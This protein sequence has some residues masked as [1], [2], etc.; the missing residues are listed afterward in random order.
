MEKKIN[1]WK[2]TVIFLVLLA[3]ATGGFF[4]GRSFS[5]IEYIPG[6][7]KYLPG[8]P[9]HDTIKIDKPVKIKEPVDTANIIAQCVCDGIYYEL[10][11]EK[12][13]DSIV[14]VSKED[15]TAILKDYATEKY[16]SEIL[17]DTDTLGKCT[18]DTK[19]QYNKLMAMSYDFVPVTR[20]Q[21]NTIVK[22]KRFSPFMG[23]GV[24]TLPAAGVCVGGYINEK[25]GLQVEGQYNINPKGIENFPKYDF[26]MKIL[27]KF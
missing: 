6:P 17:F 14:Y 4:L 1:W 22:T 2:I 19:I 24:S 15:T 3:F 27:R 21:T 7:I 20:S 11:P 12:V 16:Y 18:V 5:N 8:N 26:G 13:R 25:W 10:F 23:V 9:I